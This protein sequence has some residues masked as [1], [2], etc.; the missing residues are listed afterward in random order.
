[1]DTVAELF[2]RLSGDR[3][4]VSHPFYEDITQ[5]NALLHNTAATEDEMADCAALWCVRRQ[6]CQFGKVAGSQGGIH[7]CFLTERAVS[8]WSDHEIAEKVEEEKQL[9]KQR[10]AFGGARRA[11]S[12]VLVVASPQVALA[13]PDRHL[14]AFSDRILQLSGWSLGESGARRKNTVTGDF[15]YLKH[16]TDG[17][18]YG[19]RFNIDFFACAGD[20][21]WWHD[22]RFPGG[23][24][25]T[26]NSTG[27]MIASRE[28]YRGKDEG[29][30]WALKQ[31]MLTI[32]NTARDA[33]TDG[34]VSA[35]ER[36]ATWL[37]ELDSEGMP[38]VGDSRCPLGKVPVALEGKDWT[39]YEGVLHTD[40]A[41]REEFFV[42]SAGPPNA[43]K[44][45]LMDFTYLYDE[46]QEDFIEFTGG[47]RFTVRQVM[48]E[49]GAPEDWTHRAG[50][51]VVSRTDEEA[52]RVG[53][54]LRSCEGWDVVFG[55]DEQDGS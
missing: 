39:R 43:S 29:R 27:H 3:W 14:R 21:R 37:R 26:A 41:V 2:S 30:T 35:T 24:A 38:L 54:Q 40:H 31:A 53:E 9:W 1:M 12:F 48:D 8:T 11:H 42:E 34:G 13:A 15:L 25:F 28:W 50:R 22:H 52:F 7:F 4:R 20:G 6:P 17:S 33:V 47:K 10:S 46:H 5:A 19:F 23:I 55:I 44:P 36:R 45:Y 32:N 16:P 49:I 18:F 51:A